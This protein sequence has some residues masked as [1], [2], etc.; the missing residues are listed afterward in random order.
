LQSILSAQGLMFLTLIEYPPIEIPQAETTFVIGDSGSGKSTLFKLFNATV[1]PSK[2]M[3]LYQGQNTMDI[4]TVRLRREV[5]LV[6]QNVF[7]FDGTIRSNFTQFF[8]YR[9]E[10]LID[11]SRM[12]YFLDLCC[13]D[14]ALDTECETLSGGERQ[15]VALAIHMSLS[16][17]VLML[18]EPTSALDENT[19][20]RMLQ[21]VKAYCQQNQITLLVICHDSQI[22][23]AFA[24][25]IITLERR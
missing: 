17:T 16:P 8:N 24:D 14:F 3:I 19:A 2:G 15:R 4:D 9:E 10:A 20:H 6:S 7:L 5:L 23:E 12:S 18:D 11:E 22:V 13:A 25:K 1:S 21:Q